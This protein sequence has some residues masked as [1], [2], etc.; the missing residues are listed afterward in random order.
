MSS[1]D[2]VR[3]ALQLTAML[4]FALVLG[5]LLRGL[6]QPAVVGEMFGGILLG[7]TVLGVVAPSVY[8]WMFQ[9]SSDVAVVREA[10][11]KL[12]MLFFL[13]LAGLEVDLSDLRTMGRRIITIGL[14][15]T[16]LPIG[17][18]VALVHVVPSSFWGESAQAHFS[19]LALFMGMNMANSA[20]P[21][22]ARVLMD[23]G[24]LQKPTTW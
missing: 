14:I 23:L 5:E 11:T 19:T 24:L 22:I 8:L 20:N 10:F 1:H 9:S 3:L 16:L 2:F 15:G 17:A 13:F 4:A 18:G 21:V 6:R 7:P 12:G